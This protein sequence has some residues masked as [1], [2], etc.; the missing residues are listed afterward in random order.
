MLG[1]KFEQIGLLTNF[2]TNGIAHLIVKQTIEC[3]YVVTIVDG[4]ICF[5][6]LLFEIEYW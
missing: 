3:F 2:R 5:V 6:S 1:Q 4:H